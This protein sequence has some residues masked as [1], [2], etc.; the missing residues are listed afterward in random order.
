MKYLTSHFRHY[1]ISVT[2]FYNQNLIRQFDCV[3]IIEQSN[4]CMVN[5]REKNYE[6]NYNKFKLTVLIQKNN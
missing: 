2:T 6:V 5:A 1:N 4:I 3:E